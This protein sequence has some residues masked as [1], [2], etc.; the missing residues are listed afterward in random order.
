MRYSNIEP[1]HERRPVCVPYRKERPA[2]CRPV[3]HR[4][5]A[6]GD[7]QQAGQARLGGQQVIEAG[8]QLLLA[9]R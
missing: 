5:V 1:D 8:I 4:H 9:T 6:L 3:A 7:G 2:Q